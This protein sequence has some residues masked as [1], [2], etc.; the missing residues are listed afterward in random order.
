MAAW[1]VACMVSILE[2]VGIVCLTMHDSI[3]ADAG[4]RLAAGHLHG[5]VWGPDQFVGPHLSRMS[6]MTQE[7]ISRPS[8]NCRAMTR[9]L[10]CCI[11]QIVLCI[12]S[13]F[14]PYGTRQKCAWHRER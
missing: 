8:G 13:M 7:Y 1:A 10:S 5:W 3:V 11:L 4:V 6:L 2:C 9:A 12:C 14:F